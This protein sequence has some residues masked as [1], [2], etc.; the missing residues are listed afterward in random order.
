M[1]NKKIIEHFTVPGNYNNNYEIFDKN[2]LLWVF[3]QPGFTGRVN[4]PIIIHIRNNIDMEN[5]E[6]FSNVF[7][8]SYVIIEG[9][10]KIIS[11]LNIITNSLFNKI[12]NTCKIQNIKFNNYNKPI[13][14][15][16]E[17]IVQYCSFTEA[18]IGSITNPYPFRGAACTVYNNETGKIYMCIFNNINIYTNYSLAGGVV[19]VNDGIISYINVNMINITSSSRTGGIVGSFNSGTLSSSSISNANINAFKLDNST[20]VTYTGGICGVVTTGNINTIIARDNINLNSDKN[21]DIYGISGSS[22]S[23]K[24]IISCINVNRFQQIG[25]IDLEKIPTLENIY[26]FNVS[27]S[28]TICDMV[29][30]NPIIPSEEI[31]YVKQTTQPITQPAILTYTNPLTNFQTTA[32][33]YRMDDIQRERNITDRDTNTNTNTNTTTS[34]SNQ[35]SN[36]RSTDN[37]ST[38]NQSTDNQSTDNQ[39]TDN[40]SIDSSENRKD[41][42]ATTG[43]STGSVS[44]SSDIAYEVVNYIIMIICTILIIY[45]VATKFHFTWKIF[46]IYFIVIIINLVFL[47]VD[48]LVKKKFIYKLDIPHIIIMIASFIFIFINAFYK[49]RKHINVTNTIA[50]NVAAAI[51]VAAPAAANIPATNPVANSSTA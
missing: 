44:A 24:L 32:A 19:G 42:K 51:G 38:D 29:I 20:S 34:S 48:I 45:I 2:E 9:H 27:I 43:S 1:N 17:G 50:A 18:F 12:N 14:Y 30:P 10:G 33:S 8:S 6:I 47:L 40:Q 25:G 22:D 15:T 7:L 16:N 4:S 35:S 39:S 46:I 28:K 3:N 11:N 5:I 37:Q 13:I 41:E 21:G 49:N 31:I 36:Y 23:S 26:Y